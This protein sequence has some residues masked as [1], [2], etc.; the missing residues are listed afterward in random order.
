MCGGLGTRLRAALADLPKCLAPVNGRPFLELLLEPLEQAGLG[1]VVLCLGVG[2]GAVREFCASRAWVAEIVFSEEAAPLGTGGALALALPH[3]HSD[4]V[5]VLNGDSIVPGLDYAG[6]FAAH[7]RHA[8][9]ASM[10]VVRQ[11]ERTDAGSIA[12]DGDG[13]VLAFA[14]KQGMAEAGYLSAGIYLL[15]R[16][17]VEAIP[18]GRPVSLERELMPL[19]VAGGVHAYVHPGRLVDIG[20]PERLRQ[21]Q[22]QL[23][24]TGK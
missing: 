24:P 5:L 6:F 17:L 3:L 19:W 8:T 11:D 15:S 2:A 20:T 7:A 18:A 12:L 13:R 14:E 23:A 1:R 21:A 9:A 16:R 10:V 4:P 22:T